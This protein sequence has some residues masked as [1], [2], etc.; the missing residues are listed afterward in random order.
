M[1]RVGPPFSVKGPRAGSS[2]M[3]GPFQPSPDSI[4]LLIFEVI[5]APGKFVQS[6]PPTLLAIILLRKSACPILRKAPPELSEKVA[7]VISKVPRLTMPPPGVPLPVP[8][9]EL[10]EKVLFVIVKSA[11]LAIPPADSAVLF[12]KTVPTITA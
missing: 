7:F 8:L 2:K 11:Q 9:A 6:G 10:L 4:K 5:V 12:S 1:V 3:D